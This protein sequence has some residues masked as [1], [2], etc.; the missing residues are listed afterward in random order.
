MSNPAFCCNSVWRS[1][2]EVLSAAKVRLSS[3]TIIDP[4]GLHRVIVVTQSE[5][6]LQNSAFH[7]DMSVE[8]A[9]V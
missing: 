5:R 1:T 9:E 7:K 3:S 2:L 8:Q 6:S 4:D